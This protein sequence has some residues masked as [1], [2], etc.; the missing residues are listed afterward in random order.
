MRL[1]PGKKLS[2]FVVQVLKF[3]NPA[4]VREEIKKVL[5]ALED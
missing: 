3:D 2:A 5:N 4:L 1:C